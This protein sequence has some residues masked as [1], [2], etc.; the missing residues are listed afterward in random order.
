MNNN[1]DLFLFILNINYLKSYA[2]G[3][4]LILIFL[5]LTKINTM[6]FLTRTTSPNL[7]NLIKFTSSKK[8]KCQCGKTKDS[9]G[10]CD[11]SHA[12]K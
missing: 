5:F 10:N 6:N 11:G 8:N 9:T 1:Q 3:Y 7:K 4:F 2:Y 12:N